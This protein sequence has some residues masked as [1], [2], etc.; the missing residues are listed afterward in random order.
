VSICEAV[1]LLAASAAAAAA[2]RLAAKCRLDTDTSPAIK[3]GDMIRWMTD[4][5]M[6]LRWLCGYTHLVDCR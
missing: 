2:E 6:L 5:A 1:N 4:S 3:E